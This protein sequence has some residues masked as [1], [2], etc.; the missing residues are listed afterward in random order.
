[1]CLQHKN[2]RQS[3]PLFVLFLLSFLLLHFHIQA[4]LLGTEAETNIL[5]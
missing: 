2:G 1:M 4:D 5:R 3:R